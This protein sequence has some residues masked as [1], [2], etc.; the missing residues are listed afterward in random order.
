MA[1][2]TIGA[3]FKRF[4]SD[5]EFWPE[6]DT[7]SGAYVWHADELITVD[8]EEIDWDFDLT[9]VPD[10]ARMTIEG[11]CVTDERNPDKDQSFEGYF[12]KWRKKQSTATIVVEVPKDKLEEVTIAIKQ[13]GGKVCKG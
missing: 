2:K 9:L 6:P 12:K 13:A 11:G 10:E 3:E 4:Y 8:G 7:K 1:I 5:K